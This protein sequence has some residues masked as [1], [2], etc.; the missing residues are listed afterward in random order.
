MTIL[1]L[2]LILSLS[3]AL[4]KA[5][6]EMLYVIISIWIKFAVK[7]LTNIFGNESESK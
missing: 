2:I 5:I 1:K 6:Y 4:G 7:K 3:F